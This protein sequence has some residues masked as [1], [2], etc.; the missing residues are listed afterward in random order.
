MIIR[1]YLFAAYIK[2]IAQRQKLEKKIISIK[3]I[4]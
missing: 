1:I 3:S 2:N 4:E